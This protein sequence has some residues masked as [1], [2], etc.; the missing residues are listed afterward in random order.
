MCGIQGP[1]E[2]ITQNCKIRFMNWLSTNVVVL[3]ASLHGVPS[4]SE[5]RCLSSDQELFILLW[6]SESILPCSQKGLSL[7]SCIYCHVHRKAYP[8]LVVSTAMFTERPIFGWLYL[9]P[10][11]QKGLSLVSCIY[12]RVHRKAYPWLVVSTAVFTERFILG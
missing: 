6:K 8:W 7:V 11:S 3:D 5:I 4:F 9:L 2:H 10:C 1:D 12:C